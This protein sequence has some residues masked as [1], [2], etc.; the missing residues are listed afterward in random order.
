VRELRGQ[1]R[2]ISKAYNLIGGLPLGVLRRIVWV[3]RLGRETDRNKTRRN[4]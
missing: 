4:S 3:E 1:V 2:T